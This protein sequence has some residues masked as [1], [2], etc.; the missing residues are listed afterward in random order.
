[1]QPEDFKLSSFSN[2]LDRY[3]AADCMEEVGYSLVVCSAVRRGLTINQFGSDKGSDKGSGS[4]LGSGFG[5]G[6]GY[7]LGDGYGLGYGL[8]YG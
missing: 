6:L 5:D 3:A 4:G 8:G 1:M 2:R 7:G